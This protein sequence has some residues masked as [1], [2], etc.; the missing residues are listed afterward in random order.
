MVLV[1]VKPTVA[2]EVPGLEVGNA[3]DGVTP[4]PCHTFHFYLMGK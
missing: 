1:K 3:L 4:I 2:N